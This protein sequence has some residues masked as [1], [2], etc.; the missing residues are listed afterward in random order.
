MKE[1]REYIDYLRDILDAAE[2][3]ERFIEGMDFDTFSSDDK[4]VFTIFGRL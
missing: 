1:G 3:A 4:T 2:K